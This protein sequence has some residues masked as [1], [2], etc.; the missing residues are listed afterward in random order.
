MIS[1]DDFSEIDHNIF[2]TL[3]ISEEDFL[4]L[5]EEYQLAFLYYDWQLCNNHNIENERKLRRD[6]RQKRRALKQYE[7][8]EKVKEKVLTLLKKK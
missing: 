1:R 7:F 3:G 5:P 8:E 4:S 6:N 2:K